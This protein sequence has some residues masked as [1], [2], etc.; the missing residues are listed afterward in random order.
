MTSAAPVPRPRAPPP[1]PR[2]SRPLPFAAAP[3]AGAGRVRQVGVVAGG[4]G[5]AVGAVSGRGAP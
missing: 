1:G 5:A 3:F 4:A 2:G